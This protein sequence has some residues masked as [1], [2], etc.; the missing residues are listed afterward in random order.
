MIFVYADD[1]VVVSK[2]TSTSIDYLA[3]I[4]FLKEGSMVTHK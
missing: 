1:I 2:D 3:N 4:Y